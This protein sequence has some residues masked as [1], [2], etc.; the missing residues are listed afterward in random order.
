MIILYIDTNKLDIRGIIF[1]GKYIQI[2][3]V[4]FHS[5]NHF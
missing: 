2:L 5:I 3:F 1:T 4:Y